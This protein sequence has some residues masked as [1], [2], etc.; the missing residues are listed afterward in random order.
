MQSREIR[1]RGRLT[2]KPVTRKSQTGLR[3]KSE[4]FVVLLTPGNAGRGKGPHFQRS[5]CRSDSQEIDD[6]SATSRKS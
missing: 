5:I 6:E 1:P 2:V 4:R 3:R